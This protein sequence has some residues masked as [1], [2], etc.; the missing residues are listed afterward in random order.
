MYALMFMITLVISA[1]TGNMQQVSKTGG[2]QLV[3]K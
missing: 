1:K 3:N 2:I